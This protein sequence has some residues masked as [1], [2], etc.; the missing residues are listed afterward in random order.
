MSMVKTTMEDVGPE[1]NPMKC[2]VVH[3]RRGMH[4][5][6]TRELYLMRRPEY[7]VLRTESSKNSWSCLKL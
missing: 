5:V 7:Q 1:L 3:V 6:I 4:V 2:V